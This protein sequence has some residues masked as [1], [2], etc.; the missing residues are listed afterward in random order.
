MCSEYDYKNVISHYIETVLD[1]DIEKLIKSYRTTYDG[2]LITKVGGDDTYYETINR[3]SFYSDPY[4]ETILPGYYSYERHTGYPSNWG[5]SAID[6]KHIEARDE[7]QKEY[8]RANYNREKHIP[9]LIDYYY[10]NIYENN[11]ALETYLRIRFAKAIYSIFE[12]S[13]CSGVDLIKK[14]NSFILSVFP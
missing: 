9:F 12:K 3:G 1:L 7:K 6:L 11:K 13:G 2:E 8:A 14:M 10:E 5:P 4:I